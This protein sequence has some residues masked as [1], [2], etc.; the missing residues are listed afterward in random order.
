MRKPITRPTATAVDGATELTWLKSTPMFQER[1]QEEF[2]RFRIYRREE[3]FVF[4]EDYQEYF[5]DT[6]HAGAELVFDG[7]LEPDNNREYRYRDEAVLTGHT[8]SYWIQTAHSSPIGPLPVRVRDPEV[9]WSYQRLMSALEALRDAAPDLVRLSFC[10]KTSLGVDIPRLVVGNGKRGIGLVGLIH[11]GESGP[12][13]IVPALIRL[14][15]EARALLAHVRIL[16]IPSVNIDAREMQVKGVPWYLRTNHQGVDLN[17][18]FPAQWEETD[19]GYGLDSSAP[20]S[21]TYRGPYAASAP[22]TQAV[23]AGLQDEPL[24]ALFSYHSLAGICGL[25]ALAPRSA[26]ACSRYAQRCTS[27]IEIFRSGLYPEPQ[28]AGEALRFGC[29]A[30]SLPTWLYEHARVPAFDLEGG[31]NPTSLSQCRKDETDLKLLK[32]YQDRHFA[33]IRAVLEAIA[34]GKL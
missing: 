6:G 5:L 30:G 29:S 7:S 3:A 28:F 22:E 14:A 8:Y 10:G 15:E 24:D 4:G 9:W 20:D 18:N 16:A 25:P 11:G 2:S 19:Y 1:N 33:A 26:G 23:I 27:L 31:L 21:G 13:L 17:R 34:E 32:E 12:E